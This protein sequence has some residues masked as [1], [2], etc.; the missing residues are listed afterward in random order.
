MKTRDAFGMRKDYEVAICEGFRN[1]MIYFYGEDYLYPIN[2][3]LWEDIRERANSTAEDLRINTRTNKKIQR[4]TQRL[5]SYIDRITDAL[6]KDKNKSDEYQ[7][8]LRRAKI[9]VRQYQ[10]LESALF[11]LRQKLMLNFKEALERLE[12]G[13]KKE[14]GIR[15]RKA[16]CL[17]NLSQEQIASMLGMSAVGYGAY[18]RGER[19]LSTFTIYRLTKILGISADKLLGI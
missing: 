8:K 3:E 18:E 5:Q 12:S 13:Y 17:E 4:H 16:R 14:N 1:S 7:S 2:A 19:D 15:L 10:D 11:G 6:I 9:L